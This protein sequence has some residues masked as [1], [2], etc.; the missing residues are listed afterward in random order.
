MA[1]RRKTSLK[2]HRMKPKKILFNQF[3]NL[4]SQMKIL[5]LQLVRMLGEQYTDKM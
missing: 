2:R 3:S 5:F 1:D 4:T